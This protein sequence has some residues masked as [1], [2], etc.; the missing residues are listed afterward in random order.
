MDQRMIPQFVSFANEK[1][2]ATAR[3]VPADDFSKVLGAGYSLKG[4]YVSTTRESASDFA[5]SRLPWVRNL[6]GQLDGEVRNFID[7]GST[8]VTKY[9]GSEYFYRESK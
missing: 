8:D 6:T 4:V 5:S 1:D 3:L 2:P 9:M 7:I